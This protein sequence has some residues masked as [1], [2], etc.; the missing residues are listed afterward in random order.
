M[1]RALARTVGCLGVLTVL[2]A[3]GWAT[4][5]RWLPRVGLARWVPAPPAWVPVTPAAAARGRAQL[6]AFAAPRPPAFVSLDADEL[7]GALLDTLTAA[8][9]RGTAAAPVA[10]A[11]QGNTLLV[12][13]PFRVADLGDIGL[14]R[15][16][17]VLKPDETLTLGGTL[18]VPRRGVGEFRVTRLA[19]R[20]LEVPPPSVPEVAERLARRLRRRGIT[21]GSLAF[22]LPAA[23]TDVRIDGGRVTLYGVAP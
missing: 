4:R 13:V 19:V 17:G 16:S 21:D 5:A 7:A 9:A 8:L 14:G 18:G 1:V 6:A 23:V 2:T 10:A 22:A 20:E 3:A 12:R 15:L 11:A